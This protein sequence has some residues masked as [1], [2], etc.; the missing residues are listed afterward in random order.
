[1]FVCLFVCFSFGLF[2]CFACL[3]VCF[4]G[5]LLVFQVLLEEPANQG[6]VEIR[7]Y[8]FWGKLQKFKK[9]NSGWSGTQTRRLTERTICSKLVAC[10]HFHVGV[11]NLEE[12]G[13][14]MI[15]SLDGTKKHSDM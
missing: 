10:Q 1:M 14:P 13:V 6:R 3:F 4:V 15:H 12:V 7:V 8:F 9:P 2:V 11:L 5:C